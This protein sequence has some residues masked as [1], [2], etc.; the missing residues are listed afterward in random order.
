MYKIKLYFNKSNF[1]KKKKEKEKRLNLGI[2]NFIKLNLAKNPQKRNL[3][4]IPNNISINFRCK[5]VI[6]V[7][8]L[9]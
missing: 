1:S 5:L 8:I 9:I 2:L 3:V 6:I 7:S 4:N